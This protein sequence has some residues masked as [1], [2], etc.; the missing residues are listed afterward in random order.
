[1][2]VTNVH[3]LIVDDDQPIRSS[4]SHI[5][6]S[7]GYFVRSASDGFSALRE[8]RSQLP[9]IL[10][11]DLDMAGMSG[12]EL[13]S[14]VRRRFPSIHVI[15][16]SGMFS[17]DGVHPGIAADSFHEKATSVPHLLKLVK[18]GE[19]PTR[20]LPFHR[21]DPSTPIWIPK[22]G[23]DSSGVAFITLTCPDCLR[24]FAEVTAEDGEYMHEAKCVHCTT[25][26]RY[27]VVPQPGAAFSI[28]Y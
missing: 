25:R 23:H 5:F 14:I 9:D 22:N 8:I 17:G 20:T 13:L 18:A 7:L 2:P 19:Q 11:S 4:L 27:A 28:P 1:M 3:I 16:M 24:T 10:L 21:E 6:Q 12:F 26:I 15:A